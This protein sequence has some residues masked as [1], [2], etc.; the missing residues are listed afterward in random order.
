MPD[1]YL[2]DQGD[3]AV[4][5]NGDIAMVPDAY[6]NYSQQAYI[7]MMTEQGDFTMYPL[8]GASLERLHGMANTPETG[9]F[10]KKMILA[11]LDREGMFAGI[12]TEVKAV[13][14]GYETIR[15]DVYI[16]AGSRTEL[17]LAIEQDL[18]PLTLESG[19]ILTME[20]GNTLEAG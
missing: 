2:T 20:N 10:G 14:T 9:E 16:T 3:L 17:I 4:S 5:A 1:V 6:R 12:D 13:P 19:L 15:F 7:R 18:A 11:A 8:L